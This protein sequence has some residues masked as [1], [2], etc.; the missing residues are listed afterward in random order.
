M[1]VW[2]GRPAGGFTLIEIVF[3][4]GIMAVL[5]AIAIPNWGTLLPDYNLN[6]A[7]RQVESE[8]SRI[9]SQA[10]SENVTFRLVFSDTNDNYT[11]ERIEGTNPPTQEGIKSLPD[12]IDVRTGVTVGFSSRG[13]ASG[14]GT[15]FLCNSKNAGRNIVVSPTGRIRVCKPSLCNGSCP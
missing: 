12:G 11:I 2:D 5:A 10:V 15:V 4:L 14:A 13:T 9:K 6:G 8:L 3:V 7:T 1:V